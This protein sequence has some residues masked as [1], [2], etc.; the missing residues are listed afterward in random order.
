MKRL[1]IVTTHPI[2]Y[3][4]PFFRMLYHSGADICV[5]Y[6]WGE[7][8]VQKF[9]PGFNKEIRWDLP[10]LE[11]YPYEWAKNIA[12][13]PGT[14][15]FNGI[16][17][18]GLNR[19]IEN[20]KPDALLVYGWGFRGHLAVLR[21]FAGKL[22]VWFRGDSTLLD[23]E[24]GIK[25]LLRSMMLK[26]VYRNVDVALYP[27]GNTKAY[28]TKYGLKANQILFMPHAVDSARFAADRSQ[29]AAGF[30]ASLGIS[31]QDM[32]VLFAGKL[33]LKKSPLLLLQAFLELDLQNVHLLFAG[34]GPLE[35]DLKQ[36]AAGRDRV[37]FID[38]QN[39]L[40]MPVIYQACDLFCLPSA[41]PGETWGLAV[42]EA[43]AAGRAVLVSDKTGA[44]PDLVRNGEN[45]QIFTAGSKDDLVLKL[46]K[47]LQAGRS[48]LAGMGERSRN[49]IRDWTIENQVLVIKKLLDEPGYSR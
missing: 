26:R 49:I 45:G 12:K 48:G 32:M 7:Q 24:P 37:H 8:S 31:Q 1:A 5:F 41:G 40:Q 30:R 27:G 4:A 36:Q 14:H 20:W 19:Q 3:Y 13:D 18:P 2:Q 23:D 25:S 34:N 33:E 10:L 29:E 16:L 17:T 15:H 47:L 22:P 46:G 44:A 38:F 28:F 43:M 6:S 39:Q 21:Y 11:G 42:N 9:D 35:N